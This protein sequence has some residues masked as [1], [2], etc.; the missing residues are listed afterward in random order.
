[1]SGGV[2][3]GNLKV[4]QSQSCDQIGEGPLRAGLFLEGQPTNRPFL[5]KFMDGAPEE[6]R[7]FGSGLERKGLEAP[8]KKNCCYQA[9]M[10]L[11]LVWVKTQ[12]MTNNLNEAY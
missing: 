2:A 5:G 4:E 10:V 6:R 1:M 7:K 12:Q 9:Y 3:G 11:V 8:C